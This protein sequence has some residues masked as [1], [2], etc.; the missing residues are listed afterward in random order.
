MLIWEFILLIA[1]SNLI[2]WP[3]AFLSSLGFLNFAWVYKSD[4]NLN[5]FL[6]A[7]FVSLVAAVISIITQTFK[8]ARANPVTALKYE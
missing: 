3:L 6:F 7:A 8:A 4:I 5:Y 2:A 1:V